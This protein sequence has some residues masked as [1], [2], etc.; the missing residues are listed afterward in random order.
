[1]ESR[2]L[3]IRGPGRERSSARE[4]LAEFSLG[5]DGLVSFSLDVSRPWEHGRDPEWG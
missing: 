3:V 2:A 4:I 1:M 5:E